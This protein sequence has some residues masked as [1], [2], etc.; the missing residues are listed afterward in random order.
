MINNGFTGIIVTS[1]I[2]PIGDVTPLH[3]ILKFSA[4]PYTPAAGDSLILKFGATP[5]TPPTVV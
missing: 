2:R 3:L 1:S 5:Y 4:T